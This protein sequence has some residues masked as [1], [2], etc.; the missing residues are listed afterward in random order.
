MVEMREVSLGDGFGDVAVNVNGATIEVHADGSVDTYTD[1]VVRTHPAASDS[2]K[3]ASKT[4]A[5]LKPGD[6]MPDGT[7][8]AGISPDTQK[9]MYTTPVDAPLTMQWNEAMQYAATLDVH[10]HQDWR[11]PTKNELNVL[12]QNRAAIGGFNETGSGSAGSYWSSM[13]STWSPAFRNVKGGY[14]WA[15][16]FSDDGDQDWSHTLNGSSL[17]CVRG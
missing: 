5:E 7:V 13:R 17:R 8:C 6:R 16:R 14:A 2:G 15:Q 4:P 12:F 11:V 1:A 3:A 10:G 9:P